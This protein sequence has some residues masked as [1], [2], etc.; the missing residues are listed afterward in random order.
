ML[1][2]TCSRPLGEIVGSLHP[3]LRSRICTILICPVKEGGWEAVLT[4]V[5]RTLPPPPEL[6]IATAA[7]T[8]PKDTHHA[9]DLPAV[10]I[11]A[12]L[13]EQLRELAGIGELGTLQVEKIPSVDNTSD[14]P[15][16]FRAEPHL[17]QSAWR[18][19][20]HAGLLHQRRTWLSRI[21]RPDFGR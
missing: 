6:Q 7:A 8:D 9:L 10:G 18:V 2:G 14:M 11:E 1:D 21:G 5:P 4:Y 17:S 13:R 19:K 20:T 12:T 16:G 3:W 15:S